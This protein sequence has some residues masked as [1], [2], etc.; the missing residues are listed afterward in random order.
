MI[1]FNAFVAGKTSEVWFLGTVMAFIV[2]ELHT[3]ETITGK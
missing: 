2:E 1:H 3:Q